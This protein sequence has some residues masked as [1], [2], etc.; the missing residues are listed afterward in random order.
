MPAMIVCEAPA[1]IDGDGVRCRGLG[2]VRLL[3]IDAPDR[4]SAR[5]CRGQYGNH[6]CDDR[7]AAASKASLRAGLR[8]GPVRLQ[9][10]KRDRYGRLIATASAGGTDLSC[11]QLRQGSARYIVRYDDGRRV[12]RTCPAQARPSR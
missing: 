1:V 6:V 5:P 11:W 4:R 12:A 10:V 8:L 3:G 2:E 9:P 7:A